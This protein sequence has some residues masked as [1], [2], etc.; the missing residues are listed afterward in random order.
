MAK[1]SLPVLPP[2]FEDNNLP[3]KTFSVSQYNQYKKC[4]EM[5]RFRYVDGIKIPPNSAMF[6]GTVIHSG[7]EFSLQQVIDKKLPNLT[8]ATQ[9]VSDT[10]DA[11][12][13]TVNDWG[14]H[15]NAGRAKD[16]T[17][18]AYTHYH[19][20]ALPKIKPEEVESSFAVKVGTVPTIGYID[21][22]DRVFEF[23]DAADPGE[24]VIADLKYSTASWSQEDIEKDPQFTLYA[25]VKGLARVRV[26]NL[27][28]L[29][30]GPQFKQK[31]SFRDK[32]AKQLLIEDFEQTTDF[33]K[34]GIFPK[35]PIDSWQCTP[36][37]CGYWSRCRGKKR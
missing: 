10:F 13:D 35:A 31:S 27:V 17:V 11:E 28:E 34:K 19:R 33:I 9:L 3:N 37:W 21:L 25:F 29:K 1:R 26:D 18:A 6:Q 30:A 24:L 7:A 16:K 36:K 2:N 5:Y 15:V 32:Q 8:E 23:N 20:E 14:E 4:G 22:V 12:K